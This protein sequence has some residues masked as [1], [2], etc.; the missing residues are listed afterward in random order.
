MVKSVGTKPRAFSKPGVGLFV[1]GPFK[2]GH[3][4]LGAR[5]H[6]NILCG[7]FCDTVT[8]NGL[9]WEGGEET[10]QADKLTTYI[11]F[12]L[13]NPQKCSSVTLNRKVL[14]KIMSCSYWNLLMAD[15]Q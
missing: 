1:T 2:G 5:Q 10:S 6:G 13:K 15:H 14:S 9:L 7:C 8:M 12:C 11:Q 3:R 4:R